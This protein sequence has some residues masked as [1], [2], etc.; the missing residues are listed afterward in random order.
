[1]Q[2]NSH[3]SIAKFEELIKNMPRAELGGLIKE[4]VAESTHTNWDGHNRRD[5]SAYA[6]LFRDI[7]LYYEAHD[8]QRGLGTKITNVNPVT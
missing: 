8:D 7:A 6:R 5:L 3:T 4:Y 1:M 2:T